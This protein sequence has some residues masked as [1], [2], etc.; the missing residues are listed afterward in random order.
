MF[1]KLDFLL[2]FQRAYDSSK[3]KLR[4]QKDQLHVL[5]MYKSLEFDLCQLFRNEDFI[6]IKIIVLLNIECLKVTLAD[7]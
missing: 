1:R 6:Y 3:L 5:I 7:P 2:F 4:V